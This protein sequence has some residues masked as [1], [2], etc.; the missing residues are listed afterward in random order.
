MYIKALT[1]DLNT[2]QTFDKSQTLA[3]RH[4]LEFVSSQV[5][6]MNICG[7][8]DNQMIEDGKYELCNCQKNYMHEMQRNQYNLGAEDI[9][10]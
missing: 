10:Y 4:K 8:I 7:T 3:S 6:Q 1:L 9:W 5:N 2:R